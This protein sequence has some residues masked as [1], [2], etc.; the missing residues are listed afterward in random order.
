MG[1]EVAFVIQSISIGNARQVGWCAAR[2]QQVCSTLQDH[3]SLILIHPVQSAAKAL[4]FGICPHFGTYKYLRPDIL[5][6]AWQVATRI[7]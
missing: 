3:M 7:H 1:Y 2:R 5:P 6:C 4:T